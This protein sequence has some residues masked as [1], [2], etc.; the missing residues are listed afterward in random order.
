MFNNLAQALPF[1]DMR[2]IRA[3][4]EL[5]KSQFEHPERLITRKID[6]ASQGKEATCEHSLTCSTPC[7]CL[8]PPTYYA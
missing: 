8:S 5:S 1:E 3:Y 7:I 2:L 4:Y 6:A